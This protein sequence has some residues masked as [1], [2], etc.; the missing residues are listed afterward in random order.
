VV[1]YY[2]DENLVVDVSSPKPLQYVYAD[3]YVADKEY[4]AHLVPNPKQPEHFFQDQTKLTVGDPNSKAQWRIQAPFGMELVTVIASS[5]PLLDPPRLEP[6]QATSYIAELRRA[7][8][9]DLANSEVTAT[10]CF[11][12]SA[13][14]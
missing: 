13:D 4:V 5:R 8:P 10:Y 12:T 3:Y 11:I 2:R 14:K 9:Q 1:T 7:L 6:E